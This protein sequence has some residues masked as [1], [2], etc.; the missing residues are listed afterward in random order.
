MTISDRPIRPWKH[1]II[2]YPL[3]YEIRVQDVP[4]G[5]LFIR[6]ET[7]RGGIKAILLEGVEVEVE[8]RRK[9]IGKA[10]VKQLLERGDVLI[11][12][13]TEDECKPFWKKIGAVFHPLP[14]EYFGEKYLPSITTKEPQ[15]FYITKN[16]KARELAEQ[17]AIEVPLLMKREKETGSYEPAI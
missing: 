8:H 16:P 6:E 13:I 5:G 1:I 9:G 2:D 10:I 14:L 3:G 4:V 15:F 12:S 17:L 11:G 7:W